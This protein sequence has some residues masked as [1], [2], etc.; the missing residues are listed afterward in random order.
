MPGESP[1]GLGPAT[2]PPE[3]ASGKGS[4]DSL[5]HGPA[6]RSLAGSPRLPRARL[7]RGSGTTPGARPKP[8]AFDRAIRGPGPVRHG[9]SRGRYR[10]R[11][12]G[13]VEYVALG[14]YEVSDET[15]RATLEEVDPGSDQLIARPA[16]LQPPRSRRSRP[17]SQPRI[18]PG[19]PLR[20]SRAAARTAR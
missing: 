19:F 18:A 6:E 1:M 20:S 15:F 13:A 10:P 4:G 14:R 16:R 8:G 9:P 17:R 5:A 3:L 7:P 2:Q 11:R 12:T